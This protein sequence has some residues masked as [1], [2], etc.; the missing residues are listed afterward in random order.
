V[1]LIQAFG[2]RIIRYDLK[3]INDE[4]I[5]RKL[6]RISESE[7]MCFQMVTERM[8]DYV[9]VCVYECVSR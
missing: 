8:C 4:Q 2:K 3:L 5:E 9:C 6:G 7:K 1:H